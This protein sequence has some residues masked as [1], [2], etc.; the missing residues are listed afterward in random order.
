MIT[1][2]LALRAASRTELAVDELQEDKRSRR[3]VRG[4]ARGGE[5]EEDYR[6]GETGETQVPFSNSRRETL[7][8]RLPSKDLAL[9][10]E[11]HL[12]ARRV[13]VASL[14][15]DL[16][17]AV[18]GGDGIAVGAGVIK[19]SHEIIAGK[20]SGGD[21]ISKGSHGFDVDSW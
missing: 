17:R 5:R 11:R 19:E 16:P 7:H 6:N 10:S 12:P 21:E 15:I 1:G 14:P 3:G 2:D 9:R 20:D 13:R 18:D 8:K 4:Q